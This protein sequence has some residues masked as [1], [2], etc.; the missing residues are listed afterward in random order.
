MYCKNCGKVVSNDAE[1]CIN[2]GIKLDNGQKDKPSFLLAL[3]GFFS[4]LIG[5]IIYLVCANSK[6]GKSKSSGKGALTGFIT[7]IVLIIV[8]FAGY[9]LW[10][11]NTFYNNNYAYTGDELI[12]C[13]ENDIDIVFGEL[14]ISDTNVVLLDII[15][16]N[17]SEKTHYYEITIGAL[18]E[19]G[20]VL[21]IDTI[22]S[23]QVY[24]GHGVH[25]KADFAVEQ[26]EISIYKNATFKV[27][28][29]KIQGR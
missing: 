16:T 2:C 10:S 29:I 14:E 15:A 9:S 18:D 27:L 19:N 1:Y 8:L 12:E 22:Y 11:Y 17:K 26:K 4:P 5:L 3:L 21:G 20:I 13:L 6:P 28:E 24:P 7:R 25:L 23:E